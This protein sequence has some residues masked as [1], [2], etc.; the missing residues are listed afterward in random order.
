MEV[1]VE[2]KL[3]I[4]LNRRLAFKSP[5]ILCKFQGNWTDGAENICNNRHGQKI[6]ARVTRMC[7]PVDI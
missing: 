3:G 2:T 4:I 5:E 6:S 1:H 7:L